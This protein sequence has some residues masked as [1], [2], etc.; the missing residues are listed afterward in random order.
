MV[1][2]S[3]VHMVSDQRVSFGKVDWPIISIYAQIKIALALYRT[4]AWWH[5]DMFGNEHSI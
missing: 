5:Y 1:Q 2:W 4:L 3:V